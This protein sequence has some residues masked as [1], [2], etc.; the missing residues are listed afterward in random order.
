MKGNRFRGKVV[1][2]GGDGN[3]D[4][5]RVVRFQLAGKCHGAEKRVGV[6]PVGVGFQKRKGAGLEGFPGLVGVGGGRVHRA[7]SS[8]ST[9][10]SAAMVNSASTAAA[11]VFKS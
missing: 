2:V 4:F 3:G 1:I 9:S 8:I 11:M 10:T 5:R 6:L 7:A